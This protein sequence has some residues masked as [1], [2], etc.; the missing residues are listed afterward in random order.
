MLCDLIETEIQS[1]RFIW[2]LIIWIGIAY[3]P[4][5]GETWTIIEMKL[6]KIIFKEQLRVWHSRWDDRLLI[7]PS[8][9]EIFLWNVLMT[10]RGPDGTIRGIVRFS[11]RLSSWMFCRRPNNS[12]GY[13]RLVSEISLLSLDQPTRLYACMRL[14]N[15][16]AE[17]VIKSKR[18]GKMCENCFYFGS[19]GWNDREWIG[20]ER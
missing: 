15:E 5:N 17:I 2:N 7:L 13:S 8:W 9:T 19:V 3:R 1:N 6:S 10:C 20:A 18:N 14:N 11:F 12:C 4:T 16:L